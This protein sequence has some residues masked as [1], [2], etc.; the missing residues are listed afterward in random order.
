MSIEG[1]RA[2]KIVLFDGLCNLC[3]GTVIFVRQNEKAPIFQFASI[4]SEAGR[5]LLEFCG[6]PPHYDRAIVLIDGKTIYNGSTAALKIG[7]QLRFPWSL[8]ARLG[9]VVPRFIRDWIYN[10]IALNRYRWFGKRDACM[11][12]T[13][14]LKARFFS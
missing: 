13:E 2:Q 8:L 5:R 10:Q 9:M 4:Q 1:Q 7:Q 12:P 11:L 3:N 6:Y 14:E